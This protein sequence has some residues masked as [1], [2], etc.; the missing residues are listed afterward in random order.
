MISKHDQIDISKISSDK[1][2]FDLPYCYIHHEFMEVNSTRRS[3]IDQEGQS[4]TVTRK[5]RCKTCLK[6]GD[7]RFKIIRNTRF[8]GAAKNKVLR[9]GTL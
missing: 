7:E 3:K 9:G 8:F 5:C 6:M 4:L 1:V 2:G